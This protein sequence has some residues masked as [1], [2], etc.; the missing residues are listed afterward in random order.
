VLAVLVHTIVFIEMNTTAAAI[1]EWVT[2]DVARMNVIDEDLLRAH[3]IQADDPE[4]VLRAFP[5]LLINASHRVIWEI[6]YAVR[7]TYLGTG[8]NLHDRVLRLRRVPL[9][10]PMKLGGRKN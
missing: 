3:I 8:Y 5:A 4:A 1:V 7:D 6:E 9:E 2:Q 10:L